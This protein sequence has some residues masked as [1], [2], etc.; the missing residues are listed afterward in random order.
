M[1]EPVTRVGLRDGTTI[2]IQASY[3]DVLERLLRGG[4]SGWH[5]RSKVWMT[6]TPPPARVA[7]AC[8]AVAWFRPIRT[9]AT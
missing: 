3:D 1:G 7:I 5:E 9:E 6:P 8:D 4:I 2:D